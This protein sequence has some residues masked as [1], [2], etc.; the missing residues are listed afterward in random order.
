MARFTARTL[1][2]RPRPH[3]PGVS[4]SDP[5]G[6]RIS[7]RVPGACPPR[8]P[9][10]RAAGRAATGRGRAGPDRSERARGSGS[11]SPAA[12]ARPR[13]A[14]CSASMCPGPSDG[15]QPATGSSETSTGRKLRHAVEQ[16]GVARE[17]MRRRPSIR[18]PRDSIGGETGERR[19]SWTARVARIASG[20]SVSSSPGVSSRTGGPRWRSE[21]PPPD[22]ATSSGNCVQPSQ[23][24]QVEVVAVE[25]RDKRGVEPCRRFRS[26][27]R[28]SQ[29]RDASRS[30]G[31]VNSRTP[32]SS[33]STVAWPSQV[34]RSGSGIRSPPPRDFVTE[35]TRGC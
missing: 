26:R 22:G 24:R 19:P 17:E 14:A 13:R 9:R 12:A 4:A 16:L 35:S 11:R 2:R 33:T 8:A 29:M 3:P 34:I 32:P 25:V 10:T 7:T 20:P 5:P 1:A 15:P 21:R 31:S 30:T 6:W 28:A 18:N 27:D 23:R